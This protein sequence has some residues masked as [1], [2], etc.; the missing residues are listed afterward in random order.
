MSV[1]FQF[2]IDAAGL[3]LLGPVFF[4]LWYAFAWLWGWAAS[5]LPGDRRMPEQLFKAGCLAAL[6][7]PPILIVAR[8]Y[9]LV[10]NMP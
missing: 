6:V 2:L 4:F 7:L 9:Q 8:A 1:T 5:Y 10:A 3:A